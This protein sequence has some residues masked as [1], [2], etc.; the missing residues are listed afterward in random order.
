MRLQRSTQTV[1]HTEHFNPSYSSFRQANV[2]VDRWRSSPFSDRPCG[3]RFKTSIELLQELEMAEARAYLRGESLYTAMEN[4]ETE[5][6]R[7]LEEEE[8][9]SEANLRIT[10]C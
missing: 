2:K 8:V 5:F 3:L 9:F 6:E 7:I 10:C 1:S 4:L